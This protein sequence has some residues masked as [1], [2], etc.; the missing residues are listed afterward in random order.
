MLVRSKSAILFVVSLTLILGTQTVSRLRAAGAGGGDPQ[1]A[2]KVS[3]AIPDDVVQR[4]GQGSEIQLNINDAVNWEDLVRTLQMG[5]VRIAL[6]DGSFLNIGARSV[7]K[8][9]KH[10]PASQQTAI[11]L[12]LGRVRARVVK[13]T[14]SG[15]SFEMKTQTAVLGVVGTDFIVVAEADVTTIYVLEGRLRV[16]NIDPNVAGEVIVGPGQFTIVRRGE[17]PTQPD[18]SDRTALM[19]VIGETNVGPPETGEAGGVVPPAGIPEER[20]RAGGLGVPGA[21]NVVERPAPSHKKR[22][23]LI[24]AA[25]AAGVAVAIVAATGGYGGSSSSTSTSTSGTYTPPQ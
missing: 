7:M 18:S 15:A 25:I 17:P 2:G 9:T 3:A 6:L 24:G 8:I 4:L 13:L 23:I 21:S 11:E 16:R 19:G 14:Q 12:N 10:D 1:Q 22:N 20:R 5:R